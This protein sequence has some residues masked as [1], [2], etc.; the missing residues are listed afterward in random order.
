MRQAVRAIVITKGHLLVLH[1]NKFGKEYDT[2]PGGNIELG[3]TAEAALVRE[4]ADETSIQIT[5]FRP[6]FIEEAG[7]PYGT[8]Y[9]YLCDYVAGE[10]VLNP[11][12]EEAA[13]H[14]MGQNLY[15]PMWVSLQGL[16]QREFLSTRLKE[17]ILHATTQGFPAHPVRLR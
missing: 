10:P 9:I 8:Q 3:E 15:I 17:A 2:L 1:R 6:V 12:S 13:I 4:I 16:P 7:N 11:N 5:N 14:R